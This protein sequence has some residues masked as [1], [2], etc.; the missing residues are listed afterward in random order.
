MNHVK[1]LGQLFDRCQLV[2]VQ[3]VEFLSRSSE[4]A[5][6]GTNAQSYL[7]LLPNLQTLCVAMH[8]EPQIAL[9]ASR[10]L[11]ADAMA[12]KRCK[13]Q[14]RR[15]KKL[16]EWDPDGTDVKA[17]VLALPN[18]EWGAM[19][20]ELYRMFWSLSLYDIHVPESA[21]EAHIA[22]LRAR[23]CAVQ[24]EVDD[25]DKR[26]RETARLTGI[27][28][29]LSTE[30][31]AQR[32]HCKQIMRDM[33]ER[34][35]TLLDAIVEDQRRS[36][37]EAI[38]K[39]CIVPRMSVTPE[40]SL[41]CAKFFHNMHMLETPNFSSLQ[42][43]DRVVKDIFPLVY[44]ATDHEAKCLGIFLRALFEPLMRWRFDKNCYEKEAASKLGFSVAIGSPARCSYDQYCTVFSKWY[45]KMTKIT[46]NCFE[47]YRHHGRAC[48]LVLI[49]LVGVFP[50]R[51]RTSTILMGK[52]D[53][54]KR[55]EELKDV[56]AMA[57]RYHT[58]LDKQKLSPQDDHPS[59]PPKR[60][61]MSRH[62]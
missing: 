11:I 2:L 5:L 7:E 4:G 54:L 33:G 39:L 37:S 20:S 9:H 31:D 57:Y 18:H 43:Y 22:F 14:T 15:A 24:R 45:D 10:P 35:N 21:Y 40:D 29:T 56:Q 55:Q 46:V 6:R 36:I 19:T 51:R 12:E 47:Q 3:L 23:H 25:L 28:D 50:V 59:V 26:K 32:D 62:I 61:S 1:L 53:A 52:L 58:L 48:L 34:R 42:F 16:C 30:L 41:F 44:C 17:A 38:L 8:F 49:K 13:T 27:I 60:P